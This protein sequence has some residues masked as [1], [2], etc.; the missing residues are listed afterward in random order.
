MIDSCGFGCLLYNYVFMRE[1]QM[2]MRVW[3]ECF[4]QFDSFKIK[5][6]K[7]IVEMRMLLLLNYVLVFYY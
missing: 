4:V 6:V 1:L 3:Y 2:L 7:G 5:I